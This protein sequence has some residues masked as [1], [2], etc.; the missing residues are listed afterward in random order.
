MFAAALDLSRYGRTL[1][2]PKKVLEAHAA[3]LFI[4]YGYD[5]DGLMPYE[6]GRVRVEFIF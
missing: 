3:A 1:L 5:R 4:R 2:R 6:V